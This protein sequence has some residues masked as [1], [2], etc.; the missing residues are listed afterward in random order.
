MLRSE[1]NLQGPGKMVQKLW[2]SMIREG[3][4]VCLDLVK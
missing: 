4:F 1:N 3:G 2:Y